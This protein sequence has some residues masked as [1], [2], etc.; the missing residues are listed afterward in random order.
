M[1]LFRFFYG[2]RTQEGKTTEDKEEIGSL[3]PPPEERSLNPV[4]GENNKIAL[5]SSLFYEGPVLLTVQCSSCART[6][7]NWPNAIE[8]LCL[9]FLS[10]PDHHQGDERERRGA[11]LPWRHHLPLQQGQLP[12]AGHEDQAVPG[13]KRNLRRG[14]GNSYEQLIW[15]K[16]EEASSSPAFYCMLN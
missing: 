3:I 13:R 12:E 16:A 8:N 9:S 10:V 2:N 15:D 6:T 5:L 14:G 7:L 4:I 1:L 11:G